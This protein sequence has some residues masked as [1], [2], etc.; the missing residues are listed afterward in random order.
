[1]GQDIHE[2]DL[3]LSGYIEYPLEKRNHDPGSRSKT[4]YPKT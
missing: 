2:E 4:S 3:S 1:M